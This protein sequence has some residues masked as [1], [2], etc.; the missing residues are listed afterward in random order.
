MLFE[1]LPVKADTFHQ[2]VSTRPYVIVAG[3]LMAVLYIPLSAAGVYESFTA[4][5]RSAF[6]KAVVSFQEETLS[7]RLI[8]L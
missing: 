6:A 1:P 4:C 8:L 2:P 3:N 7:T 5:G